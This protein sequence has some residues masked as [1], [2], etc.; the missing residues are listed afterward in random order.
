MIDWLAIYNKTPRRA[1]QMMNGC[2]C[3]VVLSVGICKIVKENK[4]KTRT[5]FIDRKTNRTHGNFAK[6]I[7]L[8]NKVTGENEWHHR[9]S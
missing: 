1:E 6:T 5:D 9:I 2:F 7:T 4:L 3:A 8:K